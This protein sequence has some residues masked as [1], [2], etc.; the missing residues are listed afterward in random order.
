ML[1]VKD[2]TTATHKKGFKQRSE[3]HGNKK[4]EW[5]HGVA[6]CHKKLVE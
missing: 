6:V 2:K 1:H 4:N 5:H 3:F